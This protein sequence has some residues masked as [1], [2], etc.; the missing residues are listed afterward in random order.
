MD[1]L[2]VHTEQVTLFMISQTMRVNIGKYAIETGYSVI[3][4]NKIIFINDN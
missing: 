4:T 2:L 3:I 1:L